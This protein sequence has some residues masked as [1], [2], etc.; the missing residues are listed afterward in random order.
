MGGAYKRTSEATWVHA[1]CSAWIDGAEE[2][3]DALLGPIVHLNKVAAAH[4]YKMKCLFCKQP[5]AVVQCSHARCAVAM[6]PQCV[7][8]N[9]NTGCTWRVVECMSSVGA[10]P[11]EVFCPKHA[12]SVGQALKEQ[13][14]III[15]V[16][17]VKL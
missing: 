1:L 8:K 6:H 13:Q 10:F 3:G 12:D 7:L 11:R 17:Q 15:Y 9:E 16:S 5:G 14:D 4:R 2:T